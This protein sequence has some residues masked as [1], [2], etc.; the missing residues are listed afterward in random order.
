MKNLY[1]VSSCTQ[2][3]K[4]K[5]RIRLQSPVWWQQE[6]PCTTGLCGAGHSS[7]LV[8][9]IHKMLFF[10]LQTRK[11]NHKEAL[12]QHFPASAGVGFPHSIL[13][14]KTLTTTSIGQE[15][16]TPHKWRLFRISEQLRDGPL[17]NEDG[18]VLP[19]DKK[20]GL[21]RSCFVSFSS[22]YICNYNLQ[23]E[24]IPRRERESTQIR[25]IAAPP[26]WLIELRPPAQN[27]LQV[28]LRSLWDSRQ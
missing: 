7:E 22:K 8:H 21:L 28:T 10:L 20:T 9:R 3:S 18:R 25:E 2:T 5:W 11:W 27:N 6:P 14:V 26:S 12:A 17:V 23:A 1:K 13:I 24:N 19:G 16:Q 15:A 4:R